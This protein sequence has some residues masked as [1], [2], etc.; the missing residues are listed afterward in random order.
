MD[1]SSHILST[2]ALELLKQLIAIPSFSKQEDKT[3]DLIEHYLSNKEIAVNRNLNNVWA[4]NR[5]FDPA[6]PTILLNSHHDTVAPNSQYTK[7]PFLPLIEDGKLFGLGSTDAGGALVSLLAAFVYFNN[8]TGLPYNIVIAATAE[9]EISGANGISNLFTSSTFQNCFSNPNSFAIVG[10]PTNLDLAIAEKGLLVLDCKAVGKPGHAAREEGDNAIYHAM[11]AISWFQSFRFPLRSSFLGDVKMN[12]TLINTSNKTHNTI[13]ADCSFV[14]DVR[15][16]D[17]YTNEEI[18]NIIKQNVDVEVKP[19]STR[20]RSTFIDPSHPVVVAGVK[21][22]KKIFGS[23]TLSDKSL[24][25]FPSVKCGP[26]NSAQSHSADEYILI[27]DV[28]D[29]IMFYIGLIE[30]VLDC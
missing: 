19:R 11:N 6:K 24:I 30:E 25:P 23:S 4:S 7:D 20:L 14:V 1:K 5:F 8:L 22:G 10:E 12:V 16:V 17:T 3:A 15:V 27:K 9:E 21:S 18:I 13:P 28:K 29:G 26:G 2:D